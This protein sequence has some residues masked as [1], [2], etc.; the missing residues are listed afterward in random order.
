[1]LNK[2]AKAVLAAHKEPQAPHDHE[3]PIVDTHESKDVVAGDATQPDELD[4][5]H[6]E[7]AEH[8]HPE[9]HAALGKIIAKQ[10]ADSSNE[11]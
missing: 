3:K 10:K 5:F 7:M 11:A 9:C 6:Q 2:V 4:T 8:M 1:M